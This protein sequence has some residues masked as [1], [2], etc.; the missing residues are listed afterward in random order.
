MAE[1]VAEEGVPL[2][3]NTTGCAETSSTMC[4]LVATLIGKPPTLDSAS[5]PARSPAS[6]LLMTAKF[7]PSSREVPERSSLQFLSLQIRKCRA[8][9]EQYGLFS[10]IMFTC[11]EPK[12]VASNEM[13]SGRM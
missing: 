1:K 11:C 2:G 9:F 6:R 10:E 13:T 8:D 3:S 4:V 12:P 7:S 5:S